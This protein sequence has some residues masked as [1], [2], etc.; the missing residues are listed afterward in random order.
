[1]RLDSDEFLT[2]QEN[3]RRALHIPEPMRSPVLAKAKP[4]R[5]QRDEP[6]R[7][8]PDDHGVIVSSVAMET[9][10][11][12]WRRYIPVGYITLL[13]G[14]PDKGKS[15]MTLDTVARVTTGAR[16]PDGTRG[17]EPAGAVIWT[18]ED[19]L[20]DVIRPRLERAG[21]D[22]DRIVHRSVAVDF[23]EGYSRSL[24]VA[25]TE[26]MRRDIE[27]VNAKLVVLDPLSAFLGKADSHRD[28][29]VRAALSTMQNL[30]HE[31]G[32]ASL[33]IRHLTKEV[34]GSAMSRGL[35]SI[36]GVALSRSALIVGREEPGDPT[37]MCVLA[38]IKGNL[39]PAAPSLR[40][41][42]VGEPDNEDAPPW[43]EWH[44]VSD[45]SADGACGCR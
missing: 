42:A 23:L 34:G 22:T 35:G 44:G 15:L 43:I 3:E 31:M 20:A 25:D 36:A 5:R 33:F 9:V 16:M 4:Q 8:N 26:R 11:W 12:L 2:W 19:G 38:R 14:E 18:V 30:L 21:A 32:V 6:E 7:D 27:R 28:S 40:Y 24:T 39:G 10:A 37:S 13:D 17:I 1:M 41:R 29:D 45:K